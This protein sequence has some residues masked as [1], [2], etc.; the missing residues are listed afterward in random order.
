MQIKTLEFL[1]LSWQNAKTNVPYWGWEY[2]EMDP[3]IEV[4]GGIQSMAAFLDGI[5]SLRSKPA[6]PSLP[7]YPWKEL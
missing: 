1:S 6:F 3:H 4:N 2:G 5:L 7:I